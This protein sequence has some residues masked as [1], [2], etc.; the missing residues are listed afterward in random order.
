MSETPRE[1]L[2]FQTEA[3][4]LLQLMI[5]SLYSNKEI[6]L[7][8]LISNAS[9]AIDKLRFESLDQEN[10]LEGQG[11][12]AIHVSVDKDAKT[13][14]ISDNG[15]GMTRD[16]AIEHLGTI[17]KSG[18]AN[19]MA[20]L[21]GNQ[22]KDA[23]LIGQ[24][25]VGFYSAFIVA[26]RVEVHSRRAGSAAAE[27]ALWISQG[28]ADFTI[29][30]KEK[31]S[32]GT[33]I[34]LYL[35][36]DCA[37]FADDWRVR[38]VIKKYSDHI[39]VPVMMAAV[40]DAE[41]E[42]E[43]P[44]WEAINE[45]TALWTRPKAEI[46]AEEYQSFYKHI[47]HDFDDALTW[48]HNKVEGKLEY[49][50]LLYAPK[51]APFDLWNRDMARGLKLYV[52]RTFIMDEAEQFLPLYLRFIKGVVDSN[53]LPL[54]VSREIL[55]KDGAVESMRSALTKR[56]LD[57]LT[58]LAKGDEYQQFWSTFGPV[59]KEGLGEDFANKDKIAKLLRFS[60]THIDSDTQD[61]SFEE[62]LGRMKPEQDK[63]YYVFAENHNTAKRSPHLEFFR[64][65]GIEVLILSDRIDDWAMM[66]LGEYQGKKLQDVAKGD[67]SQQSDEAKKAQEALE[68]SSESLVE[69]MKAVLS[70]QVESVRPSAR[71]T[72]SPTCLVVGDFDMGAQMRRIMEAAGQTVPKTKPVL[73]INPEHPLLKMLDTEVDEDKF[74]DLATIL[75]EQAQLAEGGQLEDPAAYVQ[76]LNALL[77]K[78]SA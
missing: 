61:Q 37:D 17:A 68:Q 16:E 60:T 18:T 75:F 77:L 1:T 57:M 54:N 2:G 32:R 22:K 7:R 39:S 33:S 63:I 48:S 69:R 8:E 55:Q 42:S 72:E 74:N 46:T 21:T 26:D 71:L 70:E 20:S 50:S 49:T 29:E 13:L 43:S 73:E 66:Q 3:K 9:D 56:V 52:K 28:E 5:H 4:Q 35:K 44:A 6:F 34:T 14:T 76:R 64:K 40:E 36:D 19:F 24:F 67:L 38:S 10:L 58:K 12:Y 78:L 25:G 45:A 11:E 31:D 62:Y 15:I 41:T 59:I 65:E 27:G 53:D 23:Q 47:S 30:S 51:N